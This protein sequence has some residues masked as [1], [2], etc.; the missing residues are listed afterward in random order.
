MSTV[1]PIQPAVAAQP[2]AEAA[3]PLDNSQIKISTTSGASFCVSGIARNDAAKA[4]CVKHNGAWNGRM[5]GYVFG[6]SKYAEVCRDLGLECNLAM[7][8]P[9]KSVTVHFTETF[10]WD[11]DMAQLNEMFTQ[12]GM[13]RKQ[14]GVNEWSGNLGQ[15]SRFTAAFA[16]AAPA[17]AAQNPGAPSH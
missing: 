14:G 10:Q 12:F 16:V 4:I 1:N 11:G 6:S 7:V 15:A 9:A 8:D 2:V 5:G 17:A 13:R 3:A